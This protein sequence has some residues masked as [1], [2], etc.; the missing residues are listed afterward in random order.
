MSQRILMAQLARL[1]LR[2]AGSGAAADDAAVRM[3]RLLHWAG[4]VGPENDTSARHG[5]RPGPLEVFDGR[6]GTRNGDRA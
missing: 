6:L 2:A 4:G 5:P 3:Y 1:R